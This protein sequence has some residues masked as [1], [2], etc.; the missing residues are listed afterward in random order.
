MLR[1]PRGRKEGD[2]DLSCS[3]CDVELRLEIPEHGRIGYEITGQ[4]KRGRKRRGTVETGTGEKRRELDLSIGKK[5]DKKEE[6]LEPAPDPFKK[7]LR[8]A[9]ILLVISGVLGII[10]STVTMTGSLSVR[11]IQEHASGEM[12]SITVWV[13]NSTSGEGIEGALVTLQDGELDFTTLTDS[14]GLAVVR[15]LRSG[16][17]SILIRR[18]GYITI[19][20]DIHIEKGVPNVLDVPMD[21]GREEE[22]GTLR[23]TKFES[24]SHSP[25]YTNIMS[26]LMLL[27]SLMA[28]VGAYFTFKREFFFLALISAYLSTFSFGFLLG[29]I[30]SI[31]GIFLII[32]GYDGFDHTYRLRWLVDRI[33][34]QKLATIL[35]REERAY[36]RLPP[37]GIK[38]RK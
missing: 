29:T 17:T 1:L 36:P 23:I 26:V 15:N 37:V 31:V 25:V 33:R 3:E 6:E 5:K 2:F 12:I 30:L 34:E 27:A 32:F 16:D 13:F 7:R 28:F 22:V 4:R 14:E 24:G 35:R 19:E 11:D 8:L 10:A 20:G 21:P 9:T 38:K 18:S